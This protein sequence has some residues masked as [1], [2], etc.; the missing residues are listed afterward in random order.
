MNHNFRNPIVWPSTISS[1]ICASF[2]WDWCL[3]VMY[4]WVVAAKHAKIEGKFK[5]CLRSVAIET[6]NAKIRNQK[7]STHN[8]TWTF[9]GARV[10]GACVCVCEVKCERERE[11]IRLST[12]KFP[13][14]LNLKIQFR[15]F[16]RFFP[17]AAV[18][19][20]VVVVVRVSTSRSIY[21]IYWTVSKVPTTPGLKLQHRPNRI[22][23]G[24]PAVYTVC[25]W[26]VPSNRCTVAGGAGFTLLLEWMAN[27]EGPKTTAAENN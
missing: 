25:E 11:C 2:I 8:N 17:S 14:K 22:K 16:V 4:P 27:D 13:R 15:I 12:K 23:M 7:Q 24:T 21:F 10:W 18:V 5:M 3:R 1:F 26:R 9:L 20:V 6:N 19:V